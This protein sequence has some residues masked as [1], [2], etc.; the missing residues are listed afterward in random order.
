[1]RNKYKKQKTKQQM[2]YN[3]PKENISSSK[4]YSYETLKKLACT[5][6]SVVISDWRAGTY[7]VA[8]R[9]KEVSNNK[10]HKVHGYKMFTR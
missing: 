4:I 7:V 9:E 2:K 6:S 5:I 10:N 3:Y 8:Y 1:M